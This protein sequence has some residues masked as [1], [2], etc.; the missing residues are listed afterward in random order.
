MIVKS[1]SSVINRPRIT[2]PDSVNATSPIFWKT[3]AVVGKRREEWENR[4]LVSIGVPAKYRKFRLSDFMVATKPVECFENGCLD[5]SHNGFLMRGR[6]GQG[7][8]CLAGALVRAM[9]HP[10]APTGVVERRDD[11]RWHYRDGAVVWWHTPELTNWIL[12]LSFSG[13]RRQM[14]DELMRPKVIVLDDLGRERINNDHIREALGTALER[15]T[16]NDKFL[17]VTTNIPDDNALAEY[18]GFIAS[19]LND[20]VEVVLPPRDLRGSFK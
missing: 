17:I 2:N 16:S 3:D 5:W 11:G 18:E 14:F 20:I 7:K 13:R 10:D 12:D 1:I 8:S 9:L 6:F 4:S 15:W 19:R